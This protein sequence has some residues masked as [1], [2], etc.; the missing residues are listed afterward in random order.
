MTGSFQNQSA[1][2]PAIPELKPFVGLKQI[3]TGMY[4]A[5]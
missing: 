2:R 1:L 4:A 3:N 5:S